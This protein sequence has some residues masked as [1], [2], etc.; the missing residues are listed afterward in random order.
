MKYFIFSLLLI[1]PFVVFS[2]VDKMGYSKS[3]I[4]NSMQGQ[5]CK[6]DSDNSIWYCD[7]NGNFQNYTFENDKVIRIFYMWEFYNKALAENNVTKE[8]EAASKFY[9]RPSMRGEAAAWFQGDVLIMIQYGPSNGKH[10]STRSIS[11]WR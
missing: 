9:G 7:N 1:L 3:E 11:N 6:Q 8:I 2:Q 5:P 4:M 10:Y